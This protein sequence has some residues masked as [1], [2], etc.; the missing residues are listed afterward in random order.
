MKVEKVRFISANLVVIMWNCQI[1]DILL[2]EYSNVHNMLLL[3]YW[4]VCR[5]LLLF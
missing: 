3:W 1:L 4:V 2:F 5:H